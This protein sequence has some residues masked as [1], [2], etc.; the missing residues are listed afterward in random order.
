MHFEY[1][2][3]LACRLRESLTAVAFG[4]SPR[5]HGKETTGAVVWP[6][7]AGMSVGGAPTPILM[8]RRK[9]KF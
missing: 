8:S 2:A 3:K 9:A 7:S 4:S 1:I 6:A 5:H